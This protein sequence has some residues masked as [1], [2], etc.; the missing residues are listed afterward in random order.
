MNLNDL[1]N[2]LNKSVKSLVNTEISVNQIVDWVR[3]NPISLLVVYVVAT[4]I[5]GYSILRKQG[6][7]HLIQK[8]KK[9][10]LK[11]SQVKLSTEDTACGY[12]LLLISP[13][14]VT[15][16]L[17]TIP[18][19]FIVCGLFKVLVGIN[20]VLDINGTKLAEKKLKG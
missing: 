2:V 19:K 7:E 10:N 15:L 9:D 13:L 20:N 12:F 8:A 18:L 4:W 11:V 1:N 14:W 17:L 3:L 6:A 5:I 16:H